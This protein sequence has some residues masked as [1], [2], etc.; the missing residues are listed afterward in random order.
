MEPF[1]CIFGAYTSSFGPSVESSDVALGF[2][3]SNHVPMLNPPPQAGTADSEILIQTLATRTKE[4]I[5]CCWKMGYTLTIGVPLVS[6]ATERKS[7]RV[8]L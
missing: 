4:R 5:F 7:G 8:L 3:L 2:S 1:V 6:L